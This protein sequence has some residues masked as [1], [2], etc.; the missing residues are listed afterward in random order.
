MS[1]AANYTDHM[2]EVMTGM[3]MGVRSDSEEK[4]DA[5]VV[6]LANMFQKDVRSIRGKLSRM[7]VPGTDEQL[8]VRKSVVSK[9]TGEAPAKKIELAER[10]IA[11]SGVDANVVDAERVA[12]MNKTEIL[13]FINAFTPETEDE[14]ES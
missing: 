9:T 1:K 13:A 12:K 3:Y 6:E 2:V 8:Y 10:L 14:T 7:T 5:V 4:R 11:V